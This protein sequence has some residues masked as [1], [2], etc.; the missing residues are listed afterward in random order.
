MDVPRGSRGWLGRF[1]QTPLGWV[2]SPAAAAFREAFPPPRIPRCTPIVWMRL[3]P[4]STCLE[5]N[6]SARIKAIIFLPRQRNKRQAMFLRGLRHAVRIMRGFSLHPLLE[7]KILGDRQKLA[8]I[9]GGE[10]INQRI[11]VY[12]AGRQ[13][14]PACQ[15]SCAVLVVFVGDNSRFAAQIVLLQ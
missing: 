5:R 15:K 4:L 10:D 6:F 14:D 9:A 3:P 2:Y 8:H 12:G 7:H 1:P 11:H 13:T